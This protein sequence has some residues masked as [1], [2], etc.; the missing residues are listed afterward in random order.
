MTRMKPKHRA[1][2]ADTRA[3]WM[4]RAA[5]A[6]VRLATLVVRVLEVWQHWS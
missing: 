2:D 3:H 6:G 1:P 4:L 5:E